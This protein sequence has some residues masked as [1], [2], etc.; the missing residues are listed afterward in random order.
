VRGR[1]RRAEAE[2][3]AAGDG[4]QYLAL[5]REIHAEV[6]RTAGDPDTELDDL[7]RALDEL[8]RDLRAEAAVAAFRELPAGERYAVLAELFDDGELREALA[9]EH[10]RAVAEA[11]R[12]VRHHAL[13]AA[14]REAQALD[15]RAVPAGAELALGLFRAADVATAIPLGTASAVC[16]RR[17]VLRATGTDATF[18]VIDDAF[19][20]R[21]GLFVT[22]DYDEAVWQTERLEPNSRVRVG[23]LGDGFEPVVHLGG[24][25]DLDVADRT[26]R[27]R[28][29]AGYATVDGVGLFTEPPS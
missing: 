13:V 23:A 10:A 3:A 26:R 9:V 21:H 15:T 4:S 22:P 5:A 14:V 12:L 11:A 17:L 20:P 24:R 28:L 16:A 2:P 7:A 8:P 19:N 25:V 18:L 27:G 29:H 1:R 6:Q